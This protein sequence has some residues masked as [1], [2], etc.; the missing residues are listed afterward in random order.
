MSTVRWHT[1][2]RKV[3]PLPVLRFSSFS[4]WPEM[5]FVG[6]FLADHSHYGKKD[7]IFAIIWYFRIL[8]DTV[9]LIYVYN[10]AWYNSILREAE[11]TGTLGCYFY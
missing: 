7:E 4:W 2:A 6:G 8:M 10:W 1:G 3:T 11:V 9:S 5:V